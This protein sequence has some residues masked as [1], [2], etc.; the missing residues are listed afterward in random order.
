MFRRPS[1][2]APAT[3][4]R[5]APFSA[6]ALSAW[7]ACGTLLAAPSPIGTGFKGNITLGALQNSSVVNRTWPQVVN[8]DFN[9]AGWPFDVFVPPSYDGTKPYGVMVYITSDQNTGGVVLQTVSMSGL[10]GTK[11]RRNMSADAHG[12][13]MGR[14][15]ARLIASSRTGRSCIVPPCDSPTPPPN[16]SG[17]T[18][19]RHDSGAMQAVAHQYRNPSLT[20]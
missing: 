14:A 2:A 4:R 13:P 8:Y 7:L 11:E 5:L 10:A 6:A 15:S 1:F 20:A 17:K 19:S 3:L 12:R 9:L 16:K 18:G